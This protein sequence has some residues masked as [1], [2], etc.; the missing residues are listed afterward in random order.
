MAIQSSPVSERFESQLLSQMKGKKLSPVRKGVIWAAKNFLDK[1]ST[2]SEGDKLKILVHAIEHTDKNSPI[3]FD[4][5][6]EFNNFEFG[7]KV[8]LTCGENGIKLKRVSSAVDENIKN[9]L[10]GTGTGVYKKSVEEAYEVL[11][12]QPDLSTDDKE[13]IIN[14]AFDEAIDK[15]D[16]NFDGKLDFNYYEFGGSIARRVDKKRKENDTDDY[17]IDI[18]EVEEGGYSGGLG[19]YSDDFV[20]EIDSDDYEDNFEDSGLDGLEFDESDDEFD[21]FKRKSVRKARRQARSDRR[22]A[23]REARTQKK[24]TRRDARAQRKLTRREGRLARKE[25]RK[26]LRAK[27][28]ERRIERKMERKEARHLKKLG[29]KHDSETIALAK[30][31]V[32]ATRQAEAGLQQGKVESMPV[33]DSTQSVATDMAQQSPKL[34]ETTTAQQPESPAT[35]GGG[36]GGEMPQSEDYPEE[37]VEEEGGYEEGDYQE[38]DEEREYEDVDHLPDDLS[39]IEE[40]VEEYEESESFNNFEVSL[41]DKTVVVGIVVVVAIIVTFIILKIKK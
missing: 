19:G 32:E 27:G 13:D 34:P 21:S 22:T 4:G 5:K 1:H 37:A 40:G 3:G 23:R 28:K 7:K 39:E 6:K 12:Q 8:V 35:G 36:G 30:S 26:D 17:L 31:Q 2:L 15:S 38:G 16:L 29:K 10:K 25:K 11:D 33:G 18:E 9:S 41:K 20:E 14:G 24:A